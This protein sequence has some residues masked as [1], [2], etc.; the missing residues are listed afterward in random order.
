[1]TFAATDVNRFMDNAR[2]SM[3]GALDGAIQQAFF[4]ALTEFCD[5]TNL[6]YED[7]PFAVPTGAAMGD[8]IMLPTPVTGGIPN[9]LIYVIDSNE[10]QRKMSMPQPGVLQFGMPVDT[11]STWM[12]RVAL[13]PTDPI[14]TSVGTAGFPEAPAWLLPQYYKGLL[15]GTMSEMLMQPAKPYSNPKLA[16]YHMAIFRGAISRGKT[17]FRHQNLYNAN[18]W[19]FPQETAQMTAQKART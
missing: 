5:R 2:V 6:W 8:T 1:M 15:S 13:C 11:G 16:A 19:Q 7:I 10:F 18:V 9:R 4:N 12:A 17:E 14:S 3:P